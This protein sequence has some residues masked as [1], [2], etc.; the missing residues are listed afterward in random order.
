MIYILGTGYVAQAYAKYFLIHSI[1]HRV[2]SRKEV[3][4]TNPIALAQF[5]TTCKPALVINAS[6]YV[7]KPTVDECED[8]K[9]ACLYGNA[10]L[11]GFIGEICEGLGI[12]WIHVSSG[13]IYDGFKLTRQKDIRPIDIS[14]NPLLHNTQFSVT[15]RTSEY[16][17][18][19]PP[20][21]TFR[22]NISS[23]YSGSKAMG[24]EILRNTPNVYICRLRMPFNNEAG[25]RNY[26]TKLSTYEK[27]VNVSNSISQIDE[28]VEATYGL[29]TQQAPCGIYNVTNPGSVEVN[30][31]ITKLLKAKI[32]LTE[33][34]WITISELNKLIRTPRSNCLLDSTK[35]CQYFPLTEINTA[36]DKAI[37]S[38]SV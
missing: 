37:E 32:R 1:L 23:Y 3:Q 6:G 4:Y 34:E 36:I 9:L 29:W 17:E 16:T 27:L 26:L 5:L 7:G 2:I 21:F 11:P 22:D 19:D 12:P 31:V 8:H 20:N 33:P 14:N 13:C 35:V 24:E 28:F 25:H 18:I 38:W 15:S 30:N 10:I